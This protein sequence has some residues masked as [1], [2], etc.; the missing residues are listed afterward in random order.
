M[1]PTVDQPSSLNE[2]RVFSASLW[3]SKP[4][5]FGGGSNHT[6]PT[7]PAGE[8]VAVLVE[9][10]DRAEHRP[11]D[12]TRM[13]E[14]VGRADVGGAGA[15]GRGVVLVD[16]RAQPVDH[17]AL[18]LDRARRGRV[19]HDLQRRQVVLVAHLLGQL[20]HAHEHRRHE[21]RVRDVV[22]LDQRERLLGIEVLHRDHGAAEAHR[23]HR[24]EQRRRVIQRRGRQVDGVAVHPPHR[25]HHP[26]LDRLL[27]DALARDLVLHALRPPRRPRR[28]QHPRA[29]E[30]LV[31]RHRR[32]PVARGRVGLVAVDDARRRPSAASSP[33]G[34]LSTSSRRDIA[35]RVRDDEHLRVAV[36]ED[37]RDLVGV[38]MR[39][40]ARE[41]QPRA[42]RRPTRLEVLDPVLH[43]NRDV[44][45]EPQPRV[46]EQLRE[47]IRAIV[48]LRVRDRLALIPPSHKQ[49]GTAVRARAYQA[50]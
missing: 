7:S 30:L 49:D 29:L 11:P 37:V 5:R 1:S 18:G 26:H 45:P 21:L 6:V 35:Q 2:S 12:R 50:T 33:R 32:I 19:Q 34:I 15:F 3:Y 38:E 44:I 31:E 23:A 39:V 20:Q 4:G 14:P 42:L 28:I 25:R 17:L 13:R 24:I 16:D 9:D 40:D 46:Q 8:L 36:V 41:E 22:L 47:L 48:Q 43:Q 10:V 27:P